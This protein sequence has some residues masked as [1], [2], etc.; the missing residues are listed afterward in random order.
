MAQ[1]FVIPPSTAPS[2]PS[3][4]SFA[5][6]GR[7]RGRRGDIGMLIAASML[8]AVLA[9]GATAALGGHVATTADST[10]P[11]TTVATV[12]AAA[13]TSSSVAAIVAADSP[14]VVTIDVTITSQ[15][16]RSRGAS[17][18]GVGSGFIYDADGGILTA[19]HVIEGASEIT[20]TLA[21]GRTFAGTVA[22]SDL[23]RDVAVVKIDASGLP[24]IS[25]ASLSTVK[26]GQTV[27]AIGDPLG[28][29][30]GSVTIGIVSG[31]GR[32]IT[33]A[34]ELT[35]RARDLSGLIQTDAAI[36]PGNSGGPLI[37]TSGAVIGII[38]AGSSSAEGVGFAVPISAAA[39]VMASAGTA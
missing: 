1:P 25:L 4:P 12:T 8:S 26:A 33:V 29:Y 7:A 36:N 24:T 14:A 15:G 9:S 3:S 32:S 19:A 21:D 5:R 16:G 37:D 23:T 30:P 6:V 2:D 18:T 31:L 10:T 22:A 13:G 34:D 17:A 27:M 20:V 38:S 28:D 39:D 35:G 11:A